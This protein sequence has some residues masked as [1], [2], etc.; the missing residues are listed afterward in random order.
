[1]FLFFVACN[2]VSK[3]GDNKNIYAYFY[4]IRLL[5]FCC[6]FCWLLR[7]WTSSDESVVVDIVD[8]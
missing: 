4:G 7:A 8:C 2:T 5:A 3:R 1:M 6:T